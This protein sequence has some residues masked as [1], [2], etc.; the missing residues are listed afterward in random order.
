M[1]GY[2][3]TVAHPISELSKRREANG[4]HSAE[5]ESP[6]SMEDR[7]YATLVRSGEMQRRAD[8]V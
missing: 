3:E 7:R 4:Q 1:A 2:G 5:L 8:D 6:P